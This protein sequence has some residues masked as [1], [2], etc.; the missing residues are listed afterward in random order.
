M[1][2]GARNDPFLVFRFEVRMDNL[3]VAGFSECSGLQVETEVQDYNE[4]GLN[5]F[6]LKFPG[7]T[8]QSN[9]TFK[10]G[11]VDTNLWAWYDDLSQGRVTFRGGTILVR[12]ASGQ[13]PVMEW[14]FKRA[15]PSK[16][17]GPELNATA[18]NVA[19]ETL[20]LVHQGLTRVR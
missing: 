6:V 9:L 10:R 19:I 14:Q 2:N 8:K 11:I 13:D 4:G 20:E 18:N 7:R 17:V 5:T 16:W 3:P 1:V 12:D 15:F